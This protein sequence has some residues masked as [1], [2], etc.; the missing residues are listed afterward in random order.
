MKPVKFTTSV[1]SVA[2]L[3]TLE[4]IFELISLM[5]STR[6]HFFWNR[7]KNVAIQTC[8]AYIKL[9]ANSYWKIAEKRVGTINLWNA[10]F[11]TLRNFLNPTFIPI[12]I[13][14]VIIAS[15]FL[16]ISGLAHSSALC[17]LLSVFLNFGLYF[18]SRRLAA[19]VYYVHLIIRRCI[20]NG[21]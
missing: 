19:F 10:L 6:F 18:M 16:M 13:V 12:K 1:K 5:T 21:I 20:R 3:C 7:T 15:Y 11:Y 8:L 17:C 14:T 2:F 9:K 4:E